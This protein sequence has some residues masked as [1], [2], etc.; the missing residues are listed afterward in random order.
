M[1]EIGNKIPTLQKWFLSSA[2]KKIKFSSQQKTTHE[3]LHNHPR[4]LNTTWQFQSQ[5]A[6]EG[7]EIVCS[8]LKIPPNFTNA[9]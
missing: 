7:H 1:N 5:D 8:L 2:H 6:Q 9:N 4:L 3:F